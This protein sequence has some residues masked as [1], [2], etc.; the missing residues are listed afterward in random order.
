MTLSQMTLLENSAIIV[1]RI[2]NQ[3]KL[4]LTKS[5]LLQAPMRRY[6]YNRVY[7]QRR[8]SLGAARHKQS[9]AH[10]QPNP[11]PSPHQPQPLPHINPSGG[12]HKHCKFDQQLVHHPKSFHIWKQVGLPTTPYCCTQNQRHSIVLKKDYILSIVIQCW[13][14]QTIK[15]LYIERKYCM[16]LIHKTNRFSCVCTVHIKNGIC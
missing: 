1:P 15:C 6:I 9:W 12:A 8:N 5:T 16:E 4:L 7:L 2:I 14:F 10:A 11:S 3:K 13:P